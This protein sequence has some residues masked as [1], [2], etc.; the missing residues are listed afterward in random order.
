MFGLEVWGQVHKIRIVNKWEVVLAL[1]PHQENL[2]SF[3]IFMIGNTKWVVGVIRVVEG[4]I[5]VGEEQ[6]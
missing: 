6:A 2:T 5:K 4:G 3:M 1:G